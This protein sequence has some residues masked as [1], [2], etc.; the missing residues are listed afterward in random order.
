M[1]LR[2]GGDSDVY[3][4]HGLTF[5]SEVELAGMIPGR[6]DVTPDVVIRHGAVP[7]VLSD[8]T[9]RGVLYE[10]ALGRYL[11]NLTGQVGVRALVQNGDEI[12][13][14]RLTK[15]D[16]DADGLGVFLL[17]ACMAAL[18]YQREGL[19]MSG[20]ALETPR[21]AVVIAG[22]PGSGAS[23]VAAAMAARGYPVLADGVASVWADAGGVPC[24]ARGIP[25]L[26]LWPDAVASLGMDAAGLRRIR[27]GL[28]KRAVT[29]GAPA[30][31]AAPLRAVYV[32]ETA[33]GQEPGLARAPGM[34]ALPYLRRALYREHLAAEM[35]VKPAAFRLI[36]EMVRR[37]RTVRVIRPDG[38]ATL[39]RLIDRL[40]ADVAI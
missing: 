14:D 5:T 21:G 9:G 19:P 25:W 24:V 28:E 3:R 38:L 32:L 4:L 33:N 17:R 7:E 31:G 13:L 34:E 22:P 10:A 27:Q 26:A 2:D 35:G 1:T 16:A 37:V 29:L 39:P 18:I 11:L 40:A 23:T 15:A 6:A 30:R 12:L 20:A 8:A 36:S